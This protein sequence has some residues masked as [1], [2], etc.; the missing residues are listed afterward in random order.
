MPIDY[1]KWDK[2]EISDDSDIEVHPNVDKSSFIRWKQ[3]DIHEKRA[4]REAEVR[5]LMVQKEMYTQLTKRVN[6]LLDNIPESNISNEEVR[7]RYLRSEFDPKE[8]CTIEDNSNSPPYNEMVEDLFT[9]IVEDLNKEGKDGKDGKLIVEKVKEHRSKIEGVLKQIDPKLKKFEEEKHVHITSEDYHVGFDSSFINRED[10]E[11][12]TKDEKNAGQPESQKTTV[13]E[14]INDVKDDSGQKPSKPVDQLDELECLPETLVFSEIPAEDVKRSGRF[15]KNH[16]Y[17]ACEQQKDSLM[18]KAFNSQLSGDTKRTKQIVHQALLLQYLDDLFRGAVANRSEHRKDQL[19]DMFVD[20][21]S[22][23]NTPA[24]GVF[25]EDLDKM[26]KHIVTRCEVI[27]QEQDEEDAKTGGGE[28]E[29]V[30]QIQLRSMDPGSELIVELPKAG[31]E[32]YRKFEEIP[33]RMRTALKTKNLDEIN[34]VF[35]TMSVEEAEGIL[36]IFDQCGVI[37]VQALLDN[38]EQFDELKKEYEGGGKEED[39]ETKGE[40]ATK[41]ADVIRAADSTE[42]SETKDDLS[43]ADIVD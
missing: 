13:I 20:K 7:N 2:L 33:E 4:Q 19:V 21:M 9:Q 42:D 26:Y 39:G 11:K 14:T 37:Q 10:K 30:E 29:G 38:E 41:A 8:R 36:D 23:A 1:S 18:M 3:R 12:G 5:G 35:A 22:D 28:Q 27:K 24:Y 25:M 32:E 6:R 40:G 17:I 31:T 34:K 16:L 15:V 43:T